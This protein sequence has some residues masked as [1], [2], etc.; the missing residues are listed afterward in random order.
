[1][2]SNALELRLYGLQSQLTHLIESRHQHHQVL[3]TSWTSVG[4]ALIVLGALMVLSNQALWKHQTYSGVH[5]AP[6]GRLLNALA[7]GGDILIGAGSVVLAAAGGE[8][9]QAL[10]A[11]VGIA[12]AIVLSLMA[13]Y[14]ESI[15]MM[16]RVWT[17][18]K[19]R[20]DHGC[21]ASSTLSQH[22]RAAL[23]SAPFAA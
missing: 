23:V 4:A 5:P 16:T 14:L 21:G 2:T 13:Y 6:I 12:I 9:F 15:S 7:F 20:D 11:V 3:G 10:L 18:G 22:D 17:P 8:S 1:M 19:R